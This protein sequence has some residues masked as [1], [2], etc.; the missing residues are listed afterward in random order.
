MFFIIQICYTCII[1]GGLLSS[2]LFSTVLTRKGLINETLSFVLNKKIYEVSMEELI[3]IYEKK[4]KEEKN[5]I[6]R[7]IK[8]G[9]VLNID[10]MEFLITIAKNHFMTTT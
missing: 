1:G 9:E 2:M 3:E 4:S 5:F 8:E 10:I 7:T 6:I